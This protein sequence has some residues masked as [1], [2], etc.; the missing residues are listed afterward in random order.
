[1]DAAIQCDHLRG[2][3]IANIHVHSPA[4]WGCY[5]SEI[6]GRAELL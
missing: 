6:A 4:I 1:L 5:C 2:S 3:L